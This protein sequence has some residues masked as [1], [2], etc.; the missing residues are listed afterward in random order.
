MEIS[1]LF[2]PPSIRCSQRIG[3]SVWGVYRTPSAVGRRLVPSV[4]GPRSL[5]RS[6]C[7]PPS[8]HNTPAPPDGGLREQVQSR[9]KTEVY[10]GRTPSS[11]GRNPEGASDVHQPHWPGPWRPLLHFAPAN[12]SLQASARLAMAWKTSG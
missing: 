8:A 5:R 3:E 7:L 2:L 11:H 1:H 10:P 6:T 4:S 12:V 9:G